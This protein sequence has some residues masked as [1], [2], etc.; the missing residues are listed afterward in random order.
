MKEIELEITLDKSDKTYASG[1]KITGELKAVI[2]EEW[3]CE[4]L[5]LFLCVNGF[6]ESKEKAQNFKLRITDDLVKKLLYQGQWHPGRY[7]Y[8]FDIDV[9]DGPFSYK[10]SLIELSWYLKAEARPSKGESISSETELTVFP[11]I[12]M[13]EENSRKKP[14][15]VVYKE[16]PKGS[17]GCLLVSLSLF[18]AGV[19]AAIKTH[20]SANDTVMGFAVFFF[21]TKPCFYYF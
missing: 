1:Q 3:Q 6:S 21:I 18:V 20:Q 16:S 10:G 5:E 11:G 19:F 17:F 15:E 12:V 4:A 7:M 14:A 2:H 13:P 8:P 9:P